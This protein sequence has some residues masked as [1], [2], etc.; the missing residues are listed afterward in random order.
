MTGDGFLA[1]ATPAAPGITGL[2]D[3]QIDQLEELACAPNPLADP[4]RRLMFTNILTRAAHTIGELL[5]QM[6]KAL[7]RRAVDGLLRHFGSKAKLSK[8]FRQLDVN[9]D[10]KVS[11]SDILRFH[12]DT[13]GALDKPLPYIEKQLQLGVAGRACR[14]SPGVALTD[15]LAGSRR[16]EPAMPGPIR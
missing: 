10:G 7:N 14:R 12:A 4:A 5:I 6:P 2:A 15:L 1:R 11:L 13:T 3:C 9:G 8:V 16:R